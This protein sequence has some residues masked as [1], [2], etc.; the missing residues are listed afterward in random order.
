MAKKRRARGKKSTRRVKRSRGAQR[1]S[2]TSKYDSKRR[3]GLVLKN[4]VVFLALALISYLLYMFLGNSL[5]Q[6]LF[7][8][9]S[10]VFVFV[11]IAFLI[12]LLVLL[13]LRVAK[14]K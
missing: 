8:L 6:S 14:K 12:V 10:M 11:G 1:A 5:I 13:V 4:L 3:I 9:L 2:R 7:Y